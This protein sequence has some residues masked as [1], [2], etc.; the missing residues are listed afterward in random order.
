MKQ[1][2]IQKETRAKVQLLNKPKDLLQ[3]ALY[4][5]FVFVFVLYLFL[6]L[7]STRR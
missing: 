6:F 1:R 2:R 4:L 5:L 7:P 3:D